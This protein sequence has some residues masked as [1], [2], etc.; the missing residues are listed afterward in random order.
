MNATGVCVRG[1]PAGYRSKRGSP[2]SRRPRNPFHPARADGEGNADHL[3]AALGDPVW[4]IYCINE[5]R[6]D[7]ELPYVF[8]CVNRLYGGEAFLHVRHLLFHILRRRYSKLLRARRSIRPPYA[9]SSRVSRQ[10]SKSTENGLWSISSKLSRHLSI[11][12]VVTAKRD[13]LPATRFL[14]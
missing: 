9:F 5:S 10:S 2:G 13:D 11:Q 14:A 4:G 1:G 8:F 7:R 3:A 6:I 12:T